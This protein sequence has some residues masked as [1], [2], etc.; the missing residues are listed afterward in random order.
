MLILITASAIYFFGM[1]ELT[2]DIYLF[3]NDLAI[4]SL[5]LF[6]SFLQKRKKV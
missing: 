4:E 3:S 2:A 5:A 6:S 1:E